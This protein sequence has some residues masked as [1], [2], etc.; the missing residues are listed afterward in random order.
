MNIEYKKCILRENLERN[1]VNLR[2]KFNNK[3]NLNFY[4]SVEKRFSFLF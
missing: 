2:E 4:F 3:V 1:F